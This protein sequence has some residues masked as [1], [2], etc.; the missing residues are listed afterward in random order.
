MS[1][2]FHE[3]VPFEFIRAVFTVMEETPQHTYQVLTKRAE[4]L[5]QLSK[6]LP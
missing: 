1:D 3:G 2:L 5:E 6:K 4:R